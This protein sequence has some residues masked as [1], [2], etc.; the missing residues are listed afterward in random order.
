[1]IICFSD[2]F[3]TSRIGNV[4]SAAERTEKYNLLIIFESI[5][6]IDI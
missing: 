2:F 5:K 1:M 4:L 6:I 3:P